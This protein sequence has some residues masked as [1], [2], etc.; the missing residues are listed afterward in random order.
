MGPIEETD[1]AEARAQME[2]N[3]FGAFR[4]CRAALPILRAQGG[5]HIVNVSSLAGIF[6]APF[7]GLYCASKFA[8][9]GFSEALRFETRGMGIKIA[10]VEPG[11]T[12]TGLPAHRR[13]VA[14]AS[15]ASAYAKAFARFQ[16]N[17]AKDEKSAMPPDEVAKVV[18]RILRSPSPRMRYSVA[19]PGQRI[20]APLKRFLPYAWFEAL[21]ASAMGV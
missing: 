13:T 20:V 16:V 5:G 18:L 4:V 2:T 14:G 21:V 15:Q 11:D 6:G 10:L 9:E 17:Q 19:N 3:F 12:D 8:L 1:I 7:N